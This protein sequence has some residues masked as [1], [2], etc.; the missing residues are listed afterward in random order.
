MPL[1]LVTVCVPTLDGVA[2]LAGTLGSVLAQEV[3]SL[4]VVVAD[5]GS[6]DGTLDVARGFADPRV[7]V[8]EAAAPAGPAA[9]WNRALA[10]ARGRYVKVMGQDDLLLPGCLAAQV[11]V[12]ER[13]PD[14]AL[15]CCRR[16]IVDPAGRVLV[17]SR[18]LPAGLVGR[19]PAERALR[20]VV[21]SGTNPL[22]EPVAGLVRRADAE[23]VGGFRA[24]LPYVIDL[25]WWCRV[26]ERG[27]L[28]GLPEV[29]VA[30]RVSPGSWSAALA[31]AQ[32]G[33]VTALYRQ[34]R[35]RHPDAV[36]AVDVAL[37]SARAA[38]ASRA[39]RLVYARLRR[40]AART[41]EPR[42]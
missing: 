12:L 25:D 39:R 16:R 15:V 40:R 14:V 1:P 34:V 6:A 4:E 36:H 2:T 35:A 38:A 30:F 27:A 8:L 28:W 37:G 21:R 18:G 22:G 42:R 32:A 26:L 10:A 11:A 5:D 20:T 29:L 9:N 3:D 31:S 23:A 33:Q 24:A 41:R 19:V 17:R 13:A 7:R